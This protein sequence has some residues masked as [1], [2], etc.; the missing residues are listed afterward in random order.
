MAVAAVMIGLTL[1]PAAPPPAGVVIY[2]QTFDAAPGTKYPEWSSSPIDYKSRADPSKM[3]SVPAPA[4]SNVES[5]K[6]KRRFLG[7]FGGPRL[8]PTAKTRVRQTIRLVLKELPPHASATLSFDLLVLRSWDGN[9]PAYGP[10][11]FSVGV[12]G[13]KPLLATTFSNNLKLD[14]DKSSQ[15]YPVFG[16]KPK[17][18][19]AAVDRLGYGWFGDAVYPFRL[20][21]PHAADRLVVEFSSDLFEGKGTDD[22]AWGLDDVTVTVAGSR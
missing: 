14:S 21:F 1:L 4:V 18:G 12:A 2:A 6:G 5:P 9:S 17:A 11:R 19:A 15:D 13:A 10:D 22:E 7:E 16:S 8:D 3:G 20:T